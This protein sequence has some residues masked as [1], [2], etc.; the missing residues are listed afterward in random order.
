MTWNVGDASG[1]LGSP[2]RDEYLDDVAATLQALDPDLCFLQ[3]V[4]DPGQLRRLREVLGDRWSTAIASGRQRRVAALARDGTLS[5]FGVSG[6]GRPPL[7]VVFRRAGRAPVVAISLHADA[8]SSSTRNAQIGSATDALLRKAQGVPDATV[9]LAGDLNIDL[10]LDKRH[11]LFSDDAYR[12]V[13]TYNYVADRLSDAASGSGSTAEP[14]RR[15]DYVFVGG[16]GAEVLVAGPW[17]GRRVGAMDHDPVIVDFAR[18][19]RL[20]GSLAH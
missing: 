1:R 16:P 13:E 18:G 4:A 6:R 3:E 17:K 9:V 7:G 20:D 19:A 11:D 12:D 2:L 14:D 10:D 5:E 8:L 15:L